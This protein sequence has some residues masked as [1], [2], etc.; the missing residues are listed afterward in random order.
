MK[1]THLDLVNIG[2]KWVLAN[3]GCGVAFKEF[4][5]STSNSEIPDVIGFGSWG[6]SVLIECKISRSDFFK[7]KGKKFRSCCQKGMGSHRFILCPTNLI[8]RNEI[9][10]GW[11]LI[12]VDD[13]GR[14]KIKYN[15][16]GGN[17]NRLRSGMVKNIVAEHGML[18]SALRRL[19][20]RGRID[21]IYI[22]E[23][24]LTPVPA[25]SGEKI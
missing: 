12:Y 5:A 11:G 17:V 16:Y 25:A 22:P 4:K 2:Y 13:K 18:Y 20:L 15:P 23:E 8:L 1:Y 10:E 21:E 24:N 7:D 3:A 9:P 6:H 19:H 14:A